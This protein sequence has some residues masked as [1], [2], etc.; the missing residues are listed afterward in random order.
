MKYNIVLTTVFAIAIVLLSGCET[1]V[2][3]KDEL[4]AKHPEW[5][6]TTVQYIKNG[7][8]LKGMTKDQVRA[9]WGK[10]CET[11][12]GTGKH[13]WGETWEY[14]TQV[15]FFDNTGKVTKFEKK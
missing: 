13:E 9:A 5:D 3:K 11:C 6:K 12:P 7:M 2:V 15:V 14:Q 1:G 4:I 10:H 8:L